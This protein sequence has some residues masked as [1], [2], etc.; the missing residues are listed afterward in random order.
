[1]NK[2]LQQAIHNYI[3]Y[4]GDMEIGMKNKAHFTD[5]LLGIQEAIGSMSRSM[6]SSR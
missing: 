5:I 2:T 4:C 6:N 3:L 1:M